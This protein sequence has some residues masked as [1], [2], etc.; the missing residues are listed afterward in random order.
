VRCHFDEPD[1]TGFRKPVRSFQ[2]KSSGART[3]SKPSGNG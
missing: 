3:A 2:S 1:L